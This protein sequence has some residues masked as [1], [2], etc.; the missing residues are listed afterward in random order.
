[1]VSVCARGFLIAAVSPPV[2]LEAERNVLAKLKPDARDNYRRL[3]TLTPLLVVAVPVEAWHPYEQVAGGKDAHVVA[4]AVASGAAFLLTLDRPLAAR[5]NRADLAVH[6]LS[7]GEF[8]NG[9]LPD[10][11]DYPS[12]R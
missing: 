5:V 1:V 8:I 11:V 12:I 6:A 10:H 3:I 4:A 2:L 9:V 7:P